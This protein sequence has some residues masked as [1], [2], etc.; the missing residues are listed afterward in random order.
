MGAGA[1]AGKQGL[2]DDRLLEPCES[3]RAPGTLDKDP[4]T[5]TLSLQGCR[6]IAPE[7]VG[8]CGSGESLCPQT[9]VDG[10]RSLS[11]WFLGLA[12]LK[13][14]LLHTPMLLFSQSGGG[15]QEVA[16]VTSKVRHLPPDHLIQTTLISLVS[17]L[18]FPK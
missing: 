17:C 13:F 6:C 18:H 15:W 5:E 2:G 8:R 11:V 9:D 16:A 7:E 1:C 10:P 3:G 14:S 12:N 4:F